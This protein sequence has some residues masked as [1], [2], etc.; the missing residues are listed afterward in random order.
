L[1]GDATSRAAAIDQIGRQGRD[2]KNIS[3]AGVDLSGQDLRGADLRGVDLSGSNLSRARLWGAMLEGA[4]LGGANLAGADLLQTDL[5]EALHVESARC[6]P[7]TLLSKPWHC[8]T[9]GSEGGRLSMV[10]LPP[11][12]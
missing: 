7:E 2:F 6:S 4:S 1:K 10:E 11:A 3:L 12:R 5:S 9:A 8:I